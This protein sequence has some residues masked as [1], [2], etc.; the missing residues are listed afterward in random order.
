M[1]AATLLWGGAELIPHEQFRLASGEA[2]TDKFEL[3]P[4][5][6]AEAVQ[7]TILPPLITPKAVQGLSV[8]GLTGDGRDVVSGGSGDDFL[9]GGGDPDRLDGGSGNDYGDGGAGQ[10][11][12]AGGADDDVMRGGIDDDVLHGNDGIDQ[13]YGDAGR[14]YLFG[15]AGA[16]DGTQAGQRLWGGDGIDFLHA[17]AAVTINAP[18]AQLAAEVLRAGDELHGGAGGDFV[19]G[20]LRKDFLFGDD[21]KDFLH[22]D[23]LS[24]PAYAVN[25]R[26]ATTGGADQLFGDGGE[27]DLLGGGGADQLWGGADSDRLEGQDGSDQLFGGGG[28]DVLVLD[29]SA[30]YSVLGGETIDGHFGNRAQGDAVDD[31]ATD[32]LLIPGTNFADTIR[33]S[34]TPAGLLQVEY[35]DDAPTRLI[36]A[37][38]ARCQRSPA[39]RAVQHFHARRQRRRRIRAGCERARSERSDRAQR[40]L[41]RGARR[42]R[43]QRRAARERRSRPHGRRRGRRRAVR[44]GR[45]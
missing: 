28:I 34:Q 20:N 8:A 22:G 43:R 16:P 1:R 24:G 32:I 21:G 12:I 18:A 31:N 10:D 26:P 25:A 11:E 27:D 9:F 17:Y 7:R 44:A 6:L 38:L 35:T 19:Y 30:T 33:L 14:D 36:Q 5:F 37:S 3:P 4:N 13:L 23:F 2:R 15:D 39:D 29:V 42:W 45:R 41:G 40:R